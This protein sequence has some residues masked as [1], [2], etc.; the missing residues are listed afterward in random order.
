MHIHSHKK[1]K[2]GNPTI[3]NNMYISES[4]MPWS[5]LDNER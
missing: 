1:K 3:C 5:K 4:I 2:Q